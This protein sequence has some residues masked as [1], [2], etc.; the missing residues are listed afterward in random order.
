MLILL[1]LDVNMVIKFDNNYPLSLMIS[2]TVEGVAYYAANQ[3]DSMIFL[4]RAIGMQFAT[5][6]CDHQYC[7]TPEHWP[8]QAYLNV[9]F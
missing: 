7:L 2:L 3:K 9:C 6:Q 4:M 1:A 5:T 8:K